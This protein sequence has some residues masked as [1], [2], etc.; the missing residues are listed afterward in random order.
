MSFGCELLADVGEIKWLM[1]SLRHWSQLIDEFCAASPQDAPRFYGD[2]AAKIW[3]DGAHAKLAWVDATTS[4]EGL[5]HALARG[6]EG[7]DGVEAVF[8][9]LRADSAEAVRTIKVQTLATLRKLTHRPDLLAW[10]FPEKRQCHPIDTG[11]GAS[12]FWPGIILVLKR[13]RPSPSPSPP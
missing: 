7:G 8:F 2:G 9:V 11:D 3:H 1:S 6:C 13:V 10:A 4:V 12:H 5:A